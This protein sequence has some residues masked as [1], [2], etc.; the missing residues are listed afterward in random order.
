MSDLSDYPLIRC[1]KKIPNSLI[2]DKKL[3]R[4]KCMDCGIQ[5]N[6]PAD[7]DYQ[8][9]AWN[10]LML[11]KK[12]GLSEYLDNINFGESQDIRRSIKLVAQFFMSPGDYIN[13]TVAWF[14]TKNP[15]LGKTKPIDMIKQGRS[16]KL[17]K[18][19]QEMIRENK[20]D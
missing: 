2:I 14:K 8:F 20:H 12:I 15:L 10:M 11:I 5:T 13:K 4:I 3:I 19:V 17:L 18:F 7:R 16:E 1:C 9:E 6:E